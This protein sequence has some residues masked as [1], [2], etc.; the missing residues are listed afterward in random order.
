MFC[1]IR[2]SLDKLYMFCRTPVFWGL[3]AYH[4][5]PVC[6][7][8]QEEPFVFFN[9]RYPHYSDK[10]LIGLTIDL[11]DAMQDILGFEYSLHLSKDGFYGARD[12]KTDTWNGMISE[13]LRQV[14]TGSIHTG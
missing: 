10:Q 13:L 6:I 7:P 11:L 3:S 12:P 14:T 1:R 2:V 9:E 8:L 5:C 4:T